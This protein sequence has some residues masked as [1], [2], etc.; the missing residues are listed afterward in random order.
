MKKIYKTAALA[1]LAA[2]A[3]SFS[4]YAAK[5]VDSSGVPFGNG[6]PSGPHFNLNILAKN[7]DFTCPEASYDELG[8]QVYGNVIYIPREQGSDPISILME[9]GSKGPKGATDTAE[10]QVTDWCTESFPNATN[11]QGDGASLRLPANSN[12][13]AV[14]ARVTGKPSEDG[15][16]SASMSSE[17][18]YVE[19]ESGNDLVMLGMV[20]KDGVSTFSSDGETLTRTSDDGKGKGVKKATDISGLFEWSG[21]VCYVQADTDAYCLDDAGS[22]VCTTLETCC[23]DSDGDG[24]YDRCDLASDVGV[25]GADGTL[26]CPVADASG[27]LY[28]SVAATCRVYENEWVFNI[29]DFVGLLSTLENNGAYNIKLRFYPL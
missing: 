13:Y 22:N 2:A 20:D 4:A 24:A 21:E 11:D 15:S 25:V 16:T 1:A 12:G 19:D 26:Q 6:Y 8:E 23:I 5:P 7:A 9:S 27:E 29:A 18:S 10:L 28:T 17:L 14:Y 3:L